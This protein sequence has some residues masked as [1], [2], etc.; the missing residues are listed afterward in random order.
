MKKTAVII[1]AVLMLVLT[2]AGCGGS[3]QSDQSSSTVTTAPGGSDEKAKDEGT[4]NIELRIAWWG[5]QTRN[6]GTLKVMDLY[7]EKNP[8]VTLQGEYVDWSGYW[9]KLATQASANSLPDVIQMDY[10]YI[11]QYVSK[12]LLLDLKPYTENRLLDVSDISESILASGRINDGLYGIPLGSNVLS[13]YYDPAVFEAAG[14]NPPDSSWTWDD[15]KNILT[16]VHEATGKQ[17]E[18]LFHT[19][20]QFLIEY[21][22][23]QKGYSMYSEDKK[24][25]GFTDSSI[26]EF[27]FSLVYELTKS[28]VYISP[29]KIPT[30]TAIEDLPFTKGEAFMGSGWS[31]QFVAVANAAGRDVE[32]ISLPLS[33]ESSEK[34]GLYNKPSC[35]FSVTQS[36]QNKDEAVKFVSF[37]INDLGANKILLAERGVPVA[38]KVRDGIE[39]DV[40]EA[41]AKT[42]E[43]INKVNNVDK[44]TSPID[45]PD[46]SAASQVKTLTKNLFDQVAFGKLDPKSAAEQF[47]KEA[48]EILA[49]GE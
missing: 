36:S 6:E 4:K 34:M 30:G 2:L 13:L 39:N 48:N 12:N 9:Q 28:G 20:P 40:S 7:H 10:A 16:K 23:R 43:Y 5:N 1:L 21:I 17:A 35:F 45:P 8:N 25:L 49:K 42:F 26:P 33:K 46:P 37:F 19:D 14:V 18:S 27:V 11:D 29:D 24:S 3:V 47:M 15:Y 44:I 32:L 41:V 38:G 31:N 22:A